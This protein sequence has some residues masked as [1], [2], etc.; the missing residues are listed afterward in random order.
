MKSTTITANLN[1]IRYQNDSGFIIGMASGGNDIKGEFGILGNMLNPIEGMTYKLQ[2]EWSHHQD[3]GKQFKFSHYTAVA[4]KD[5]NGIYKYLVRTAKWIGP[6]I[7]Q[8]LVEIYGDKTLDVLRSDPEIVAAEIRGITETRALEIQAILIE[9]EEEEAALVELMG[10]LNIPGLRKSLPYELI[11]K[12]GSNAFEILKKNPY[13]ITQFYGSGFLIADR[14]A[15]QSL[16]IDPNS[17]FRVKAAIEYAMDQDLHS[18]GNTWIHQEH[19]LRAVVE[20]TSMEDLQRI[21]LGIDELLAREAIVETLG[22][23]GSSGGWLAL[24]EVDK[25]ETYVANKIKEMMNYGGNE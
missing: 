1:S 18:N 25:N 24:Y 3:F 15:M 21:M 17:M 19:L 22:G 7:A 2:G 11:E 16:K 8:Q 14:L 23:N 13:V 6:S 10:I 20:L 9:N 4:P 5:T 12:F